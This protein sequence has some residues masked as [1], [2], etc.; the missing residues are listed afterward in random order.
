MSVVNSYATNCLLYTVR[1][2]EY[3]RFTGEKQDVI[4]VEEQFL[5]GI[6]TPDFLKEPGENDSSL[7]SVKTG[8]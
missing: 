2:Y 5:D 3:H 7:G 8:R 1:V 6:Y 4:S